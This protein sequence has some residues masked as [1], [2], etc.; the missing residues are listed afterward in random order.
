MDAATDVDAP[1]APVDP[2]VGLS[3]AEVAERVSAGRTNAFVS[4]WSRSVWNIVRAN[5]FTL[6]NAIVG[7]CFLILLLRPR[8]RGRLPRRGPAATDRHHPVLVRPQME[9]GFRGG[10]HLGHGSPRDG[11][12]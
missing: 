3:A 8:A 9:R 12:R 10:R 2:R 7:A 5:V 11:L 1:P 4:D 6:F